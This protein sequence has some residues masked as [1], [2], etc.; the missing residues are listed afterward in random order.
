[1]L[2]TEK[3]RVKLEEVLKNFTSRFDVAEIR[4]SDVG[5]FIFAKKGN[6]AVEIYQSE[7][8]IIVELWENEEQQSE[9]VTHLTQKI[10]N[11]CFEIF[12]TTKYCGFT[13]KSCFINA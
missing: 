13:A 2:K 1:M 8:S 7:D 5:S 11:I 3:Y 9:E 4:G 10:L 12:K 6:R